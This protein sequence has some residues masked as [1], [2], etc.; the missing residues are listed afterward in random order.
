MALDLNKM[1]K[2][3]VVILHVVAWILIFLFPY[4]FVPEYAESGYDQDEAEFLNLG[5]FTKIFWALLFYGN[6]LYLIPKFLHKKQWVTFLAT[7]IVF[8][9]IIMAI[10]GM[11]FDQFVTVH[12]F[13]FLRSSYHNVI[14][15]LL[16]ILISITYTSISYQI[17]RERLESERQ[18]EHLKSELSF[19]RSQVSPHFLFNILN[20][21]VALVRLKSEDLE[22]TVQKLSSL[23][24]YMLYENDEEKVSLD[25]EILYL[26][27]YLDLQMQRFGDRVQLTTDFSIDDKNQ[28]IEPMLLIPFVENAFKHGTG[29]ID[30]PEINV[31][32]WVDHKMLNFSVKNKFIQEDEA[33]DGDSGI[34]I[35]N[36]KRRLQLLYGQNHELSITSNNGWFSVHL[37]IRLDS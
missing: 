34:G 21:I 30:N 23:M 27:N 1:T 19:L 8:F 5:T 2:Y 20:N 29:M 17:K 37:K 24:Q 9:V 25:S 14:P 12:E 28:L 32:L 13:K 26:Q 7:Q 4:I 18:K 11:M 33:K 3:Q 35:P 36:V 16:T 22:P 6:I 15:F 31:K 10:H